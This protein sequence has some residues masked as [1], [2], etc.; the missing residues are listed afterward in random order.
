MCA[1]PAG[2]CGYPAFKGCAAG[3]H[4][5]RDGTLRPS[6]HGGAGLRRGETHPPEKQGE[7]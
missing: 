7:W 2:L 1:V 4:R 5:G 6:V 3:R